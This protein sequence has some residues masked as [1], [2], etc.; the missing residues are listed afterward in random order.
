MHKIVLMRVLVTAESIGYT[1]SYGGYNETYKNIELIDSKDVK[2]V[3]DSELQEYIEAVTLYNSR[4]A[5]KGYSYAIVKVAEQEEIINLF[6]DLTNYRQA[7]KQKRA[8]EAK[9]RE[10]EDAA[11]AKKAL[12]GRLKRMAKQLGVS[13]EELQKLQS[14]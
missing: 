2:E 8:L 10:E 5:S 13:V 12:A 1:S 3:S 14:K 7:E 9:K 6:D 11:K 4:N